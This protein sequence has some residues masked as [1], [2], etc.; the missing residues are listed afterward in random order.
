MNREQK[1]LYP[2]I[3]AVDFDATITEKNE[4]PHC[5]KPMPGAI[6]ALKYLHKKG[7]IIILWTCRVNKD[8]KVAVEYCQSH[9]IPIDYVNKNI[10]EIESKYA[11]LQKLIKLDTHSKVFANYYIDDS[12]LDKFPGWVKA[13]ETI[14]EDPYFINPDFNRVSFDPSFTKANNLVNIMKKIKSKRV[15]E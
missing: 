2:P 4:F 15:R 13:L 3:L 10:P 7:C 1:K 12:N 5:G 11:H 14:F 9:D 8:L 6:T